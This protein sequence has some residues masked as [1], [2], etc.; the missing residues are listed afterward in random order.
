MKKILHFSIFILLILAGCKAT[1]VASVD[2]KEQAQS[3]ILNESDKRKFDYFFYEA[4]RLKLHGD[5]QKSKL[6]YVECLKYDPSS[7][8]CYYELANIEIAFKNY[9]G[10]QDLLIKAC[11]IDNTNKYYQTLLGDLYQQNGQIEDAIS[12]YEG[13]CNEYSDNVEYMYVLS[14]LYTK[15]N[16][17]DDAIKTLNSLEKQ[18]GINEM[19]TLEKQDLYLKSGKSNNAI[20]EIQALIKDNP[21]E[22]RYYGFLGD[23]YMYNKD[24]DK[25]KE[26]YSKI[27][28]FDPN[29]G[30]G[31]FSLAN[32]D[33]QKKDTLAFLTNFEKGLQDK[34]LSLEIKF[35]R[36]L[37]IMMGNEFNNFKDTTRIYGLFELLPTIHSDDVRSYYYLASFYQQKGLI[38]KAITNYKLGLANDAG[39]AAIWQDLL[40]LELSTQ[41]VDL[42]YNDTKEVLTIIDEEPLFYLFN[43]MACM[44]LEKWEEA[45]LS[46]QK[47]LDLSTNNPKLKGQLYA[48]LGDTF[49]SL[50]DHE[51]A[52]KSY[53]E[54]LLLDEHNIIVLNNYSYYLSLENKDLDKAEKMISKTIELEP[55]NST[56]LDTYA[57]VLFKR[58]RYFEA[59]YIIERAI[60]KGGDQS[61]V[62]VEH[63]GDI[64]FKNGDVKGALLQWKKSKELGNSSKLLDKKIE[65][66]KYIEE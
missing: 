28:E 65:S 31:Y 7:S 40:Y 2:T 63:Y 18:M 23:V 45:K 53:D 20:K 56:Y 35:Q 54:A 13:L 5:F 8:V 22:P 36:L 12:T 27:L 16:Q 62:I 10:A 50:N 1:K 44:Q 25:A 15:N 38:D 29:N 34:D 33:L 46:L 39:N 21:Y 19:I 51:N 48:N 49:Y 43:G 66:E 11:S 64:L 17:F 41:N 42:L 37:P 4:Q 32:V 47:G 24:Y 6:Y 3:I 30:M 59:K 57:W 52:F 60:D 61:D 55:G 26:S 58:G 14:Q 9:K